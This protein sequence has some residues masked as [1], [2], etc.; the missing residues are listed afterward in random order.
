VLRRVDPQPQINNSQQHLFF[1]RDLKGLMTPSTDIRSLCYPLNDFLRG[2][3]SPAIPAIQDKQRS[4]GNKQQQH[5]VNWTFSPPKSPHQKSP[6]PVMPIP[7][8]QVRD[9]PVAQSPSPRAPR[10]SVHASTRTPK[11]FSVRN[12]PLASPKMQSPSNSGVRV[13]T[14]Q[15][16]AAPLARAR[17]SLRRRS[18]L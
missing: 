1:C 8:Y 12:N 13:T 3:G 11:G 9:N 14:I 5:W 18:P 6:N 10:A 16:A 15:Q 2:G 17:T 7:V 4:A